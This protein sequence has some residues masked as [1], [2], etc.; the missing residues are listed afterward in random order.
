MTTTDTVAVVGT[1]WGDERHWDNLNGWLDC[2]RSLNRQ[3]DQVVIATLPE[4]VDRLAGLPCEIATCTTPRITHM[5]NAA[6]KLVRTDWVAPLAMDDR[7]YMHALD[8]VATVPADVDV[9]SIGMVTTRGR[10]VPARPV[11]NLWAGSG[12]MIL[13]PSYIRTRVWRE[14]GGYDERF[15]IEDWAL[16]VAAARAGARFATSAQITHILDIDSPG[17]I[18]SAGFPASAYREIDELRLY[19]KIP[20]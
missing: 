2:V 14:V 4:Q 6:V 9:I 13:G 10:V 17:R 11:E 5:T 20:L 12:D 15:Q 18:S 3:P 16:W 19:G 1:V 8:E 7:M